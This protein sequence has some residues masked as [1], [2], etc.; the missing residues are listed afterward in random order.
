M[1]YSELGNKIEAYANTYIDLYD[2]LMV[3]LEIE[4]Q[5]KFKGLKVLFDGD[6]AIITD[7]ELCEGII[8]FSIETD[9]DEFSNIELSEVDF[10]GDNRD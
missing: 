3:E 8:Y 7:T 2:S 4:V 9:D 1:K 6:I 5:R 10:L